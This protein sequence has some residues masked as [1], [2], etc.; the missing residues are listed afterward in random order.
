LNELRDHLFGWAR[1]SWTG[2]EGEYHGL[3]GMAHRG[4]LFLDEIH[5]LDPALQA[6]LL[7]VLNN[8]RYRPKM[9]DYEVQSEF[10]LVVATNDPQWRERLSDDFRDRIERVVLE[11]PA[12][13]V[14]Q[15]H[16]L[17]D[18]WSFWEFTL[19]RRCQECGVVPTEVTEDCRRQ[20]EGVFRHQ[21]LTGNWRDLMRLADQVLLLLTAARGGRPTPLTWNR[22]HLDRAIFRTFHSGG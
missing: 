8:H 13:R 15:R 18:V 9:A 6:S 10:D 11:V 21:P 20:L 16:D 22:D 5:H 19:K 17:A 4:T 3:L 14:L 2:A 1:G 12:F 7:G